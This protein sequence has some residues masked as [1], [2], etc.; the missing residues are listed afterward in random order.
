MRDLLLAAAVMAISAVAAAAV[1]KHLRHALARAKATA[2]LTEAA[3]HRDRTALQ[4]RLDRAA[5]EQAVLREADLVL[6][7]ALTVHHPPTD[8]TREG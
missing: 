3:H 1:S 6:D 2:R 5:A 7:H 4:Q 8:P